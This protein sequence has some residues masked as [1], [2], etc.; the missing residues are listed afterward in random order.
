VRNG[1][2]REKDRFKIRDL[3]ADARCSQSVLDFLSTTDV[4]RRVPAPPE[5]GAQ[6]EASEW[7]LRERRE[8]EE[9]RRQEAEMLG[10]ED[11]ERP[12][13][14]PTPSFMAS[15]EE[16]GGAGGVFPLSLLCSFLGA[17]SSS[18]DRPGRRAK[19]SVQRAAIA[20]TADRTPQN[21]GLIRHHHSHSLLFPSTVFALVYFA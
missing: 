17:L 6:G 21:S 12:L 7:G 8:R 1:T 20:R 4:G 3:L 11:E 10:T 19:G 15:A 9:E 5:D 2:G 13:F 14:L 18:W 16:E